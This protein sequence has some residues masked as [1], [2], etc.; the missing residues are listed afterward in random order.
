MHNPQF[1]IY[2]PSKGRAESRLTIKALESMGVPYRV[3][4]EG[5]EYKDYA[6][7][8]DKKNILV[9]DKQYQRDYETCDDLGLTKPAGAGAVRNFAWDH[10][11]SEGH[12]FHWVMDD[13]IKFFRRYNRNQRIKVT[14]GVCFKIMEDFVLRY[15]NVAMAGPNYTFFVTDKGASERAPFVLNTKV[16]S[17]N[18]IRNDVPFRWRGRLNED[19]I[20]SLDMLK[21]KWCTIQFNVFLQE[22][23]ATQTVKGGNTEAFYSK[24]GTLPKSQMLVAVHPDC[25]RVTWRYGRWHHFVDYTKFK[26]E[27]KLIRVDDYE[28]S[29]DTNNY[30]LELIKK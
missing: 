10:S 7:A 30:G 17:C 2:I 29:N 4:V 9:L 18:L 1:P 11:I 19:V 15:K 25:S 8:V 22:K 24:D 20:L 23:A 21:A 27:N 16:Y 14:S 26:R 5:Q 3:V 6:K 13:N 28:Y 12:K